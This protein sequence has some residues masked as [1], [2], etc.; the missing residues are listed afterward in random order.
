MVRR[1]WHAKLWVRARQKYIM[2]YDIKRALA[3]ARQ[4]GGPFVIHDITYAREYTY[5][6]C[7]YAL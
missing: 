3:G 2:R 4:E 7:M 1:A 5:A 6:L